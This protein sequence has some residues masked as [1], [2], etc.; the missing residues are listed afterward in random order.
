MTKP[1]RISRFWPP[2]GVPLKTPFNPAQVRRPDHLILC[3][4]NITQPFGKKKQQHSTELRAECPQFTFN[5][6][7]KV[8]SP[9]NVFLYVK[10]W[11]S[12]RRKLYHHVLSFSPQSISLACVIA[13]RTWTFVTAKYLVTE[14]AV[15]PEMEFWIRQLRAAV[16]GR[17]HRWREAL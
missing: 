3:H 2:K 16:A 11:K 13:Y 10:S 14:L 15:P 5:A 12:N 7:E 6:T 8:S 17:A 1:R 9:I 4:L